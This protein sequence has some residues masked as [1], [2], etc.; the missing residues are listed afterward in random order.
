MRTVYSSMVEARDVCGLN[1]T[2]DLQA[3]SLERL[4]EF[5]DKLLQIINTYP[6]YFTREYGASDAT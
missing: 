4:R 2:D 5:S 1:N 3:V 6:V